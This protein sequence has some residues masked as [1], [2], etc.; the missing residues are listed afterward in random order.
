MLY[1]HRQPENLDWNLK[2][3]T[4][5]TAAVGWYQ[6]SLVLSGDAFYGLPE[7][8]VG[9][10]FSCQ[11]SV[12]F[13][14]NSDTI[15]VPFVEIYGGGI[16][17]TVGHG[18]DW[19]QGQSGPL[20]HCK[21]WFFKWPAWKLEIL[22]L[23]QKITFRLVWGVSGYFQLGKWGQKLVGCSLPTRQ[24]KTLCNSSNQPTRSSN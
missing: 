14:K 15:S 4:W 17:R 21:I 3:V 18:H 13:G 9:T 8:L 11:I 5:Q 6:R 16:G 19:R 2:F 10:N 1:N 22:L 23:L 24:S 20:D 12:V 7:G